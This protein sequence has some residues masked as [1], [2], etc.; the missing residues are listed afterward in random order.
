MIFDR[1]VHRIYLDSGS[2]CDI[3]Y[4]HCFQ[5]LNPAIKAQLMPPR[6][7]LVGFSGERCWPICEID[8]DFTI[9]EP[10]M[11]RTETLDFVVIRENSQQN[12]LLGRMTMMK[13]GIVV[14]TV[15]HL[16]KFH[17]SQGIATLPSTYDQGKVVMAIKETLMNPGEIILETKEE[18]SHE[19]K[20]SINPFFPEQQITIERYDEDTPNCKYPGDRSDNGTQAQQYLEPIHQKKRNLASERDKAA[21]EEVEELLKA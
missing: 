10:P 21:C 13:M 12:I 11:T 8:L 17:T 6:V 7:P 9:E 20:V 19:E 5:Q 15:H 3:M 2:S 16:V 4:E 14:S 18:N 1:D